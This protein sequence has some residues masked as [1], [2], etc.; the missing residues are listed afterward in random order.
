MREALTLKCPECG[1]NRLYRDGWRRLADGS[2]AQRW[3]CRECGYRFSE[4][5]ME[6]QGGKNLKSGSTLNLNCRVCA[7]E[8]GVENSASRE[9]RLMENGQTAEKRAAGATENPKLS[10][11]L[12][13]FAW[14][15]KKEGYSESTIETR[16]KLL[17]ILTKRGANLLDKE[18]VKETL[19]KLNWC[20][21]RKA[22]AVDAYTIFLRMRGERWDPPIYREVRKLPFIP[23]EQEIDQLIAGCGPKTATFLQLLKETGMR[24]GEALRLTWA[25]ID[26]VNRTVRVTPEKGSEPRIFKISNMLL[27]MLMKLKAKSNKDR[28]FCKDLHTVHKMFWR[29]RKRVAEKLGNPRIFQIHFHTFRHWKATMEYAKTKDIL[30]VMKILGHKMIQNTLIYTQLV[31]LKTDEYISK[32]ARN[33]GEACSLIEAGFEYVCT[34]PDSLMIFRKRK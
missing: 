17:K 32:V 23:T 30:H 18:T 20:S 25:D 28:V 6:K 7:P 1:S 24:A 13:S 3:L 31:D 2:A 22:C 9:L 8:S 27:E 19:A 26:F 5:R 12:F 21:K 11:L 33:A 10:E 29:Q 16:V 4:R 34:T 14:W 15:M